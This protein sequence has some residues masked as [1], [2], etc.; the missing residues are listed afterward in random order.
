MTKSETSG[1]DLSPDT[2]TRRPIALSWDPSAPDAPLR[3]TGIDFIPEIP[4]GTHLCVFYE[5]IHDL[6]DADV[7]YFKAGLENNEYCLCVTSPLVTVARANTNLRS[8]IPHFDRHIA[9][10][11]LEIVSGHDWYRPANPLNIRRIID[12]WSGKLAAAQA[13]GYEGMRVKGDAF[14]QETDLWPEFCKYESALEESLA[15]QHIIVLCAYAMEKSG[16]A[17]VLN[18][19]RAHQST[20]AI[21]DGRW[22]FLK[23]P[24][25]RDAAREI[26]V[27]KGDEEISSKGFP[28]VE[29]LTPRER[30]VLAQIVKGSSSKEAARILGISPRTVEFHRANIMQKLAVRNTAALVRA[31]LGKP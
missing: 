5:T 8:G 23:V 12:G 13:R 25:N 21:R 18:V 24:G 31:V 7:A 2:S 28:G 4:W 6:A 9:S 30:L 17:D 29:L 27:L 26:R 14:W 1:E 16:A 15:G 19:A 10:G 22:E 11:S 20:I 3:K